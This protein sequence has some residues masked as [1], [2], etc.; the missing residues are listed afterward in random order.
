MRIP[1]LQVSV[2]ENRTKNEGLKN[3]NRKY[4]IVFRFPRNRQFYITL[5]IHSIHDFVCSS[6]RSIPGYYMLYAS[7]LKRTFLPFYADVKL[8]IINDSDVKDSEEDV[9]LVECDDMFNAQECEYVF[10]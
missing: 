9:L 10:R 8:D 4:K 5:T 2:C 6:I 1:T 7:S 3:E